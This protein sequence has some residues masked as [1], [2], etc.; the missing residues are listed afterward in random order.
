MVEKRGRQNERKQVIGLSVGDTLRTPARGSLGLAQA[1]GSEEW[2][3]KGQ[4]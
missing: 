1:E 4:R 3:I 2:E